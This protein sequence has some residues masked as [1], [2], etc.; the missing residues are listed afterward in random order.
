VDDL[1]SPLIYIS[2]FYVQWLIIYH[3]SPLINLILSIFY[4][5]IMYNYLFPAKVYVYLN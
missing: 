5:N 3:S 2:T 1:A 4:T